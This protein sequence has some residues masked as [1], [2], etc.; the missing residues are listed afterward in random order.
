MAQAVKVHLTGTQEMAFFCAVLTALTKLHLPVQVS[1]TLNGFTVVYYF[2]GLNFLVTHLEYH[3]QMEMQTINLA[4]KYGKVEDMLPLLPFV[5]I[6][7]MSWK[8]Q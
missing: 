3:F 2:Y 7:A 8:T 5:S 4:N 1:N 6:L